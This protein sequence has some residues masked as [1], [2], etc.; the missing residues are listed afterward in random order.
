M[1]I[2]KDD[3]KDVKED[4][5]DEL[6]ES[7]W[8]PCRTCWFKLNLKQKFYMIGALIVYTAILVYIF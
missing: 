8:I 5:Q 6:E 2:D 3:I 7:L 1:P 4:I